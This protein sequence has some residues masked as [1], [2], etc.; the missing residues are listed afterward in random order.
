M[1]TWGL[2]GAVLATILATLVAK[3]IAVGRVKTRMGIPLARLLP[4]SSLGRT[5]IAST[6]AA[7][8]TLA[9]KSRL[10]LPMLPRLV[11]VGVVFALSYAVLVSLLEHRGRWRPLA[12]R[13]V[14]G[15]SAAPLLATRERLP[16]DRGSCAASQGS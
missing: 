7:L 4:W 6:L 12:R 8:T 16:G 13:G 11:A 5:G 2:A 3:G 15:E 10:A 14:M 9:V 1:S